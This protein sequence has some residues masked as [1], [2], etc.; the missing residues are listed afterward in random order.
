VWCGLLADFLVVLHFAFVVF[1]V[2]GGLLCLRWPKAAWLHLPAVLWSGLVELAGWICPLT[3]WENWLRSRAGE[4]EYAGDF[5]ARYL[6]PV[7]YP[8]DL[9]RG[10]QIALG[11]LVLAL[12]ALIYWRVFKRRRRHLS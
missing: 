7:L 2:L 1:A 6:L 4:T 8:A 10:L 3:P 9:T 12:N 5:V 11:I